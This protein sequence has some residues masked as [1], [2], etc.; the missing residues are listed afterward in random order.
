MAACR[1]NAAAYDGVA[2]GDPHG[3]RAGD[4]QSRDADRPECRPGETDNPHDAIALVMAHL[5]PDCGPAVAGTADD[6]DTSDPEVP[7][8]EAPVDMGFKTSRGVHANGLA[9]VEGD[10]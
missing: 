2:G 4:L 3:G 1:V 9:A 5:P 6:V 10:E 7:L 8:V